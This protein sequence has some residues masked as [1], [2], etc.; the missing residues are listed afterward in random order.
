MLN[1]NDNVY[2]CIDGKMRGIGSA[3]CGPQLAEEYRIK[4]DG[5]FSFKIPSSSVSTIKIKLEV[6]GANDMDSEYEFPIHIEGEVVELNR[7]NF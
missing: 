5:E 7:L 2:V 1:D 3:S 4:N 6:V